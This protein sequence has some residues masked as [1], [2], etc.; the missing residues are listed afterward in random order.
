MDSSTP[1]QGLIR[2]AH[3]PNNWYIQTSDL[4]SQVGSIIV[5]D[6][7]T[8]T[9]SWVKLAIVW[10]KDSV[11]FFINGIQFG[12]TFLNPYLPHQYGKLLIGNGGGSLASNTLIR[13]IVISKIKRTDSEIQARANTGFSMDKYV[14]AKGLL[15]EN[16]SFKAMAKV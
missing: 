2:I 15:T 4:A 13:N 3:Y 14:T 7:N 16:L 11:K 6:S 9:G 8:P 5:D 12:S 10:N 1:N